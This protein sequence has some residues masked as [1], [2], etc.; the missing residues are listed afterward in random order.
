MVLCKTTDQGSVIWGVGVH[1]C[2]SSFIL[3]LTEL[4][5]NPGYIFSQFQTMNGLMNL[6]IIMK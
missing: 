6:I 5:V 3:Y 2:F 1:A 4:E